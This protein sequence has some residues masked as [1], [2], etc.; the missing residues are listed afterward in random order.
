MGQ[1]PTIMIVLLKKTGRMFLT[2]AL[3]AAALSGPG[4]SSGTPEI[5]IAEQEAMLSPIIVGSGS[6]F[7]KIINAGRGEDALIGAQVGIPRAF[8]ELHDVDDDGKMVK[9]DR[10]P[11]PARSTVHLRP[12]G[13]HLMI[14]RMPRD[15]KAGQEFILSLSFEKSGTISLPMQFA[16][17]ATK[18]KKKRKG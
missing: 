17:I 15:V 9:T 13:V 12:A 4:C 11:I 5:T 8:V 16:S 18:Q 2:L 3:F 14:F 10:I 1:K 6:L 7:C